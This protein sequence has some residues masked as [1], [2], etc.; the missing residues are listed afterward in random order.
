MWELDCEESWG[1]KKW[2]FWTVV[3]DWFPLGWTG[4]IS[5]QFKGLSNYIFVRMSKI[6]KTTP[7]VGKKY[8]KQLKSYTLFLRIWKNTITLENWQFLKKLNEHLPYDA[9]ILL[10]DVTQKTWKHMTIQRPCK[11]QLQER[12]QT[13]KGHIL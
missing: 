1:P 13:K 8:R 5:L 11:D 10:L 9:K 7:S 4:W 2:C 3:L 6:K 12:S